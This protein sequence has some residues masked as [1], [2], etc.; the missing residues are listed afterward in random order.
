[1]GTPYNSIHSKNGISRKSLRFGNS[2]FLSGILGFRFVA[3]C[4]WVGTPKI[5]EIMGTPH[6]QLV[7]NSEGISVGID[8]GERWELDEKLN[9]HCSLL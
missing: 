5:Y 8:G 4:R 1:M 2:L 3:G 9:L 7:G 6:I